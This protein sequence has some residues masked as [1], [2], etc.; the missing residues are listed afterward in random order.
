MPDAALTIGP[1]IEFY[2]RSRRQ[3]YGT[4][5]LSFV[6]LRLNVAVGSRLTDKTLE[7]I[8]FMFENRMR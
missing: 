3:G 4:D 6:H 7:I 8:I 5:G 1:P 2:N